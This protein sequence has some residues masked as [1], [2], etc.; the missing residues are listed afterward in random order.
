VCLYCGVFVFC[1]LQVIAAHVRYVRT[2]GGP[3]PECSRI[4]PICKR[5]KDLR[6]ATTAGRLDGITE[7]CEIWR[8]K[9]GGGRSRAEASG[10][11]IRRAVTR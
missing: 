5:Q 3:S 11:G 2:L 4:G 9:T 10:I 1:V 7:Q 8:P 6:Y